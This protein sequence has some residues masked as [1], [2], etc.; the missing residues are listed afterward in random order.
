VFDV[1]RG[2]RGLHAKNIL[3]VSCSTENDDLSGLGN[4]CFQSFKVLVESI[5]N[6]EVEVD[7][8]QCNKQE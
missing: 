4:L 1:L 6:E 2:Q 3:Y 8:T 5:I 7:R